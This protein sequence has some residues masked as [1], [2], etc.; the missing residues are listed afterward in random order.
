MSFLSHALRAMLV[1]AALLVVPASAAAQD[2]EED[3]PRAGSRS[4]A[5]A[6][7]AAGGGVTTLK[8]DEDAAE[9]TLRLDSGDDLDQYLFA[10]SSPLNANLDMKGLKPA[11]GKAVELT[12]RVF[13]VDEEG[14]D[15][16]DPEVDK[17]TV[18]GHN[19]GK[20]SGANN[21]WSIN[22]F[23]LNAADL[24]SPTAALEVA[25]DTGGT[26]CWAVSVDWVQIKFPFNIAHTSSKAA[27]DVTLRRDFTDDKIPD[28][29]W[30]TKFDAAGALGKPAPDDPI[31]AIG[32]STIQYE[33]EIERWDG[34]ADA[35]F[36]PRVVTRWQFERAG[37]PVLMSARKERTGWTG[38]FPA[39]VPSPTG[40]YKLV[41]FFDIYDGS[42][43]LA[44]QQ[45]EHKVYVVL[46]EPKEM[47]LFDPDS[48]PPR[49]GWLD[50]AFEWGAAGKT[51]AVKILDA[52]NAKIYSNPLGWTYGSKSPTGTSFDTVPDL[53]KGTGKYG[54]CVTFADV[55]RSL[56]AVVGVEA[57]YQ[58]RVL[59]P[60]FMTATKP[61]LD[62]NASANARPNGGTADRW[63]FGMHYFA[64]YGTK[65]YD[66]TFGMVGAIADFEKE[67]VYCK[68]EETA[69]GIR[70]RLV[71]S[72]ATTVPVTGGYKRNASGWSLYDY[73]PLAPSPLR[74][75]ARLAGADGD[76]A[77]AL[78]DTPLDPDA[79]G[80]YEQ[81]RLDVPLNVTVAGDFG[82]VA[83]IA[84]PGGV[85]LA[86]GSLDDALTPVALRDGVQLTVGAHTVPV[87][88]NGR[89]LREAGVDGPF[90]ASVKLLDETG[91]LLDTETATTAA[92]DDRAFQGRLAEVGAVTD[93]LVD[94]DA[95]S[96]D[97][98]LRVT[99][100]LH[101]TG[102]GSIELRAQLFAG[103]TWIASGRE[104]RTPGP[105]ATSVVLD[106]PATALYANGGDG[107]YTVRLLVRD[108]NYETAVDHAT[109]AYDADALQPPAAS[110]REGVVDRAVDSDGD[111]VIDALEVEPK[112]AATAPG[113]Y[114]LR[115]ELRGASG[116]V[117]ALADTTATLGT[118]AAAVPVRFPG[119]DIAR[120]GANGPYT[121]VLTVVGANGAALMSR[122]ATTGAYD[123]SEFEHPGATLTGPY[124][125]SAVD[126]DAD[127]RA[128]ALRVRVGVMV[129][130]SGDYELHGTLVDAAGRR[131]AEAQTSHSPDPGTISL[132]LDFD[133]G[134]IRAHGV[135]GPYRL[136]GLELRHSS[137][138]VVEQRLNAHTTSA[139][140]AS[141]FGSGGAVS[142]DTIA[143]HGEDADGDGLFDTL[144]VD[145]SLTVRAQDAYV[146]N[147][148]LTDSAGLDI[149]WASASPLLEPGKRVVSLRFD[150]PEIEGHGVDGPYRL[151]DL[152]IYG[153]TQIAV[154]HAH[155][156]QAYAASAFEK[157]GVVRGTVTAD[158]QPV[159]GR[160]ISL[161]GVRSILTAA[162]GTF[163]I[164]APSTRAYTISIEPQDD[165]L[166]W[167][168]RTIGN[169]SQFGFSATVDV[170]AGTETI[171]D[172]VSP[173]DV[174]P[175]TT[176]VTV[177]PPAS[178]AGWHT[179]A[180]VTLHAADEADGS[181]VA[182]I[183]FELDGA[184]E[185]FVDGEDADVDV[186]GDGT[187]TLTYRA[188]DALGNEE[189]QQ[190]LTLRIDGTP[191]T[192]AVSSPAEGATFTQGQAVAAAF[193]C[194]DA[195]GGS[196]VAE[197][198]GTVAAGQRI[199][200][201][202]PGLHAFTVRMRD[203]AGNETTQTAHYTVAA[204]TT[205]TVG[206]TAP[207]LQQIAAVKR[208]G[209]D[210]ACTASV[211]VRCAVVAAI[212][213]A[214]ARRLGLKVPRRA[215]W[216]AIGEGTATAAAG[217]ATT[218]K[219]RLTRAARR[220]ISRAKRL[221]VRLT[222]TVDGAGQ[223]AQ[224]TRTVEL[225]R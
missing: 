102:A 36:Q 72:P 103:D 143:D 12:L 18:N 190:S 83:T 151:A 185:E 64:T 13:D 37:S 223:R 58:R 152:S 138:I 167:R 30:K 164:A 90:T 106:L 180:H 9:A 166:P 74:S 93:T 26:G 61:A 186:T 209:I 174:T 165:E 63:V 125:D 139:Y 2:R 100:P 194:S 8:L 126:G 136:T 200:T 221:S 76:I 140:A 108:R 193:S 201:A 69:G 210:S 222:L 188:V 47:G 134:A 141:S 25:I 79:N 22:T 88:F 17:V 204:A 68:F 155:T 24:A 181:G 44:S 49:T 75:L 149:A 59:D 159:A 187:R 111:D 206:F 33:Y 218:V 11:A 217:K 31:A 118:Q 213:A 219:V 153:D 116:D 62:G 4:A 35:D 208:Y 67:S 70:C 42:D 163:R 29:F 128:E 80:Q 179:S 154:A 98:T 82:V 27:N 114:R 38:A 215:R 169:P 32:T 220:A 133:G 65:R 78:A 173:G 124:A 53:I 127:G 224:A 137:G 87:Y 132:A 150:G 20:L 117:I 131:V 45:S 91:A 56:A 7:A 28:V 148:R 107:P 225:R 101:V 39:D 172:F 119:A 121:A 135:D 46:N 123:P 19:V 161:R 168:I 192:A 157:A 191:P 43:L 51:D 147:A 66:P 41:V 5:R 113:E 85:V 158:G 34:G 160:A 184:G 211:A 109:A 16:C 175:P 52:L 92:Y 1:V 199:D 99:V 96:G 110:F 40:V 115:G 73:T 6:A 207:A 71:S 203:A 142:L 23:K 214:A 57:D 60:G 81:L 202:A 212:R 129:E 95:V 105:G 170:A 177:S 77:G 162:D 176:Q 156:T 15:D 48:N 144:V 122:T 84:G 183:A 178:S 89:A 196:G 197:C 97:D 171:V 10:S 198:S 86:R 94:T 112:L 55:L 146:V 182:G 104:S 3:A 195:A 54:E 145:V 205:P 130:E 216:V 120:H 14:A 21:V 50:R 189:A